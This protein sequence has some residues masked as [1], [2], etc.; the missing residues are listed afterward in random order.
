MINCIVDAVSACHTRD[1]YFPPCPSRER[2]IA[3]KAPLF[4]RPPQVSCASAFDPQQAPRRILKISRRR[5]RCCPL[6]LG[7]PP[8]NAR[9]LPFSEPVASMRAVCARLHMEVQTMTCARCTASGPGIFCPQ[10]AELV[11]RLLHAPP[12]GQGGQHSRPLQGPSSPSSGVSATRVLCDVL[13]LCFC[14]CEL[15][16]HGIMVILGS[17]GVYSLRCACLTCW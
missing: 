17:T 5:S 2:E 15:N 9:A 10:W 12:H 16:F 3:Q 6:S 14:H 1:S 13:S 4:P 7:G 11:L 8:P